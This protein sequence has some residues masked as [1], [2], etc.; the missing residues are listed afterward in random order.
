MQDVLSEGMS[1]SGRGVLPSSSTP[2]ARDRAFA[3]HSHW[4]H[5]VCP[6]LAQHFTWDNSRV[7]FHGA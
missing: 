4:E 3:T 2:P 7:L 6:S 1:C 5:D